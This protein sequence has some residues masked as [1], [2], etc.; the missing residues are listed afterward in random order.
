MDIV[1]TMLTTCECDVEVLIKPH[2]L[3]PIEQA[4]WPEIKITILTSTLSEI[5]DRYD[6]AFTSN[7][8]AAAIDVYMAGKHV[9]TLLDPK[10]FNMSP[11]KDCSDVEFVVN[12]SDLR[13]KILAVDINQSNSKRVKYFNTDRSLLMWKKLL[14][15]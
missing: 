9:I 1:S 12:A 3:C 7:S 8:T 10:T 11:L 13:Q 5:V 6:I 2:P 4:D 14:E 15:I